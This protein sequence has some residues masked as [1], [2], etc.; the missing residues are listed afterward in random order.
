MKKGIALVTGASSG[1]G[2]EFAYRFAE[3]GYDVVLVARNLERL[4]EI[5]QLVETKYHRKA[6]PIG[7]DLALPE[8]PEKLYQLVH[9]LGLE[10]DILVNNAGYA[11]FG[12]F[13]DTNL[14]A[15]LAMI[16]L[17]ITTLTHLTKR[18]L[19]RMI[20]N[21]AGKVLNVASTAAFQPGPLMAVYYA[22][23]AFV[24]SFS[25]A[26][27]EELTGTNVTVTVLC[28]GPTESGF[29]AR[30]QMEDS[31]LF[32]GKI[33]TSRA[34]ASV[35]FDGLMRGKR[36]VIPGVKNRVLAESVRFTPRRMVTKIVK[37][38]S[39]SIK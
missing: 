21:N 28:P 36:V 38:M 34:V 8:S 12:P 27:A 9:E 23:K 35:G 13:Q 33:M 24:L 29:Q 31:K 4:K 20:A 11:T 18:F 6:V 15:E 39:E 37:K 22:T 14:Q 5:A 32:K 10:I 26:I 30:A 17:N 2:E 25:E 3:E 16:Q 19:P 1:I 7:L